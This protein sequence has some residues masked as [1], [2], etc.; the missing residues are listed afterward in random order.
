MP[1][2]H[3]K[4]LFIIFFIYNLIFLF[5][6]KDISTNIAFC[7]LQEVQWRD[8]GAKIVK[9]NIGEMF[10]FHWAG[11]KKKRQA[12]VGILIKI[13]PDIEITSPILNESTSN[14]N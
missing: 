7:C 8:V 6:I 4:A 13:H 9:V 10:E 14:G 3:F 5:C 11:Y 1:V 12:G 2:E